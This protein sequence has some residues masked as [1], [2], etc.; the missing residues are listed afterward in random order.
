MCEKAKYIFNT[1]QTQ[2]YLKSIIHINKGERA[3]Q[4]P[5]FSIFR[6]R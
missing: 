1:L 6:L 4:G 5:N 2:V 3:I